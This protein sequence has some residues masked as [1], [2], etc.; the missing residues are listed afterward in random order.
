MGGTLRP[1]SL[2]TQKEYARRLNLALDHIHRNISLDISL[3]KLAAVACFSPYHFHRLFS[4][5]VG[6]SPAEYV[7]RL[8]LEKAAGLLV[9]EPLRTVT[10]IALAC[11][12]ATSA[13]FCRLFKA[14]FGQSPTAWRSGGFEKRKNG[15]QVRK[16]GKD[17]SLRPAYPGPDRSRTEARRTG[18]TKRPAVRIEDLPPCRVAYVKHMRGYEDSA[19]IGEAFETLFAW[20][21]PRGFMGP[22]MRVLGVALDNPDITPRDKCRY[23][24][25]VVVNDRAAPD[26]RVGIMTLRPGTYAVG[27]FSGGAGVFREAYGYMY[28]TWLPKSGW[29]PDDAPGFESYIGEPTGT[30]ARPR[31]I[32]DLYIPVKPL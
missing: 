25:C 26:G 2:R 1:A 11:G 31:F 10:D 24:A 3:G 14:R 8:R 23:C 9:N 12:F 21:G 20:A 28:G 18:M 30:L 16:K 5:L 27:R 29:Q 22:D 17:G 19:G 13:L 6:E 7:R 32:F 4:A 15:Q